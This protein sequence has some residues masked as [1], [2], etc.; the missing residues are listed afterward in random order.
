MFDGACR[1]DSGCLG[2]W[3]VEEASQSIAFIQ[4]YSTVT[5]TVIIRLYSL[6]LY[7]Y[8]TVF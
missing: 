7:I 8:E 5:V 4:I 1:G 2:C 3:I 6:V